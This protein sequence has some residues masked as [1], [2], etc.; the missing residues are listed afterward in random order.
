MIV[1][2]LKK[3]LDECRRH[4]DFKIEHFTVEAKLPRLRV[5]ERLSVTLL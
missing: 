3:H 2:T 5:E 4:P 1:K